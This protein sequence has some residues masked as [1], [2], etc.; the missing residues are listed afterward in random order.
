MAVDVDGTLVIDGRLNSAVVEFCEQQINAGYFLILW[1]AA[2]REHAIA[3]ARE[4]GVSHLFDVIIG[5][6]G[7]VIDDCGW[8]WVQHTRTIRSVLEPQQESEHDAKE[9]TAPGGD[10]STAGDGDCDDRDSAD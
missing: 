8:D 3:Q 6:P 10:P 4:Y 2:G 1:S 5:K 9:E 7:I